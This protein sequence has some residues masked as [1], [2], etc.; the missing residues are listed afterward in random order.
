MT[1]KGTV[2]LGLS[3]GIDSAISAYL[4]K[5]DGWNVIGATMSIYDG[6]IPIQNSAHSGCFGPNDAANIEAAARIASRLGIK[7]YCF[8]LANQYR[9]EVLNYFRSEYLAGHTPNPCI[10]C[11]QKI[12]FGFFMKQAQAEGIQFDYFATGHYANIEYDN[13]TRRYSL[14]RGTDSVKDQSYFLSYLTQ[15]QLSKIL[16]PL[17]KFT[18]TEIKKLASSLGWDDLLIRSES[19]DFIAADSYSELFSKEDSIPGNF[20]DINGRILGPHKGIIHYTIGQRRG[21]GIG[22]G[23][24]FYVLKIDAPKHEIILGRKE[25]L[26]RISLIADRIN[27]ISI[28]PPPAMTSL[29]VEVQIRQRHKA[30]PAV[31]HV[32]EDHRVKIVFDEPQIAITPGQFAAI[33]QKNL[34]LGAG[35]IT[36]ETP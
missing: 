22:G 23:I 25:D 2:L 26:A 13:Q 18:K 3:G 4:L 33:Y 16:F 35:V 24:P 1:N 12:K 5:E 27:W 21:I 30:A 11:N 28:A 31:L 20:V 36:N 19:Q 29:H 17:G 32:Q 9:Q 8:N 6:S 10:R 34:L 7:H 15:E 14:Y